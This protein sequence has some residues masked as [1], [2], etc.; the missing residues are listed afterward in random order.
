M[1]ALQLN[2]WNENRKDNLLLL[3]VL[4]NAEIYIQDDLSK[5]ENENKHLIGWIDTAIH[6]RRIIEE[7]ETLSA[8]DQMIF[9]SAWRD[10]LKIGLSLQNVK[11]LEEVS[12]K[13]SNSKTKPEIINKLGELISKIEE[14]K[15]IRDVFQ[16]NLFDMELLID[17]KVIRYS[18]K[19]FIYDFPTIKRT[20]KLYSYFGKSSAYK[21]VCLRNNNRVIERYSLL[22]DEIADLIKVLDK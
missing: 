15:R 4:K 5:I 12:K 17:P 19:G 1:I 20:Y 8:D 9:Q 10:R 6:A 21:G 7:K 13:I 18:T 2:N 3:S 14:N 11:V 22:S 16:Q